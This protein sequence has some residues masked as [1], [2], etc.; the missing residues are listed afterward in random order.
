M[1]S[2][3]YAAYTGLLARTQ[4]L[5]T[6]SNNLANASTNGFRAERDYFRGVLSSGLGEFEEGSQVGDT[7]NGFGVL[8]GSLPD[9]GQGTLTPTGNPLDLA[10]SGQGFFSIQ[11]KAG[12]RY[13]RDGSFQKSPTGVLQTAAGEPVLDNRGNKIILPSGAV[14]V[15][16]DGTVSVASP[17][18]S[19]IV[20]KLGVVTFSPDASLTPE[21]ANRF[22]AGLNDKPV[23]ANA[24]IAQGSLE[25]SNEDS[26]HGTMQL[27]LI[28]RQAEM[29][30]KALSVFD[31][32]FD[33]TAVEQ[34]A[35]V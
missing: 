5:D 31:N 26:V 34:L 20:A 35:R 8:G 16:P 9:L 18:G 3:L 25:G 32:D 10:L 29:M 27:I 17:D 6:A 2:G 1:D 11:T 28:Q 12:V 7:V 30:Q 13:T 4:A 23:A 22:V 19:A 21:G 14:T 24:E 15:A 33:K